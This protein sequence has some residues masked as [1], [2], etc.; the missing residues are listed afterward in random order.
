MIRISV[1]GYREDDKWIA[2]ALDMDI[3]G[4]ADTYEAALEKLEGLIST[5]VQ[6]AK[7]KGNASLIFHKAPDKYWRLFDRQRIEQVAALFANED[8]QHPDFRAE[9]LSLVAFI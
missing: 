5:K 8:L 2:H 3:I 9:N 6:F 7:E 1:L 4:S